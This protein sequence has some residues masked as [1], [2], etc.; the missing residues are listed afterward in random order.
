M[1]KL[2]R[3]GDGSGLPGCSRRIPFFRSWRPWAAL[4]CVL[5]FVFLALKLRLNGL[6]AFD[7]AITGWVRAAVTPG[8]TPWM[9]L[10]TGLGNTGFISTLT[11]IVALFLLA[12]RKWRE[13][14]GVATA[15]LGSWLLYSCLKLVFQRPRP[16]LPHLVPAGGYSF[17]SG[18]AAITAALYL[19]LAL[20]CSHGTGCRPGRIAIWAAAALAVLLVGISRVYLGVHYPSDVVAGWATGG[21]VALVVAMLLHLES[22][23]G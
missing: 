8:L 3:S 21:F 23:T 16:D 14:L 10:I 5:V 11:A 17:P 13:G 18:H 4:L 20:I 2:L 12:C 1:N 6:A 22:G 19:T 15:S 9:I 7:S